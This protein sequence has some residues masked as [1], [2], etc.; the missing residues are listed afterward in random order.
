MLPISLSLQI[1]IDEVSTGTHLQL[2]NLE[3]GMC[4]FINLSLKIVGLFK[5]L[6]LSYLSGTYFNILLDIITQHTQ[7]I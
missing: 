5:L 2:F 4:V 7:N 3:V 6:A 1:S